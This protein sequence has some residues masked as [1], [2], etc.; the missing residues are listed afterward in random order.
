MRHC[1]YINS[2][3]VR[4]QLDCG[5]TVNRL[6]MSIFR[7]LSGTG[8]LRSAESTLFMFDN[9]ILKTNG[10]SIMVVQHPVTNKVLSVFLHDRNSQIT[11]Y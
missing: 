6:A 7:E 9:N 1:M 11:Y 10:M 8:K 4:F 5:A 3:P 2:R